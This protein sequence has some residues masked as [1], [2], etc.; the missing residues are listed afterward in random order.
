M[1]ANNKV[2]GLISSAKQRARRLRIIAGLVLLLGIFGADT[3]YWLGTRSVNLSNDPLLE[4]NEKAQARQAE[5]LYGKQTLLIK[6]WFDDLKQPGTQACIIFVMAA[7]VAGGCFYCARLL[8]YEDEA[9]DE[10]PPHH[11]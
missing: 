7:L 4:G 3:V 8:D 10:T 5:M 6:E 11:G 2:P 9:A 1:T